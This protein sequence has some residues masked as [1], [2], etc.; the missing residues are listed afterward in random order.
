MSIRS[1]SAQRKTN[2][3]RSV[4]AGFGRHGMPSPATNDTGTAL[5]TRRLRSHDL[6]T[7]TLDLGGHAPVADA[8]RRPPSVYQV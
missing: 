7:L 6:A 8:G 3:T 5:G 2:P 1:D 4:D